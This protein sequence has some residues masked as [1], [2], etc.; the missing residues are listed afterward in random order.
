[1]AADARPP[2]GLLIGNSPN[3]LGSATGPPSTSR[4]LA[5]EPREPRSRRSRCREP[6][7]RRSCRNTAVAPMAVP[8]RRRR[9][10]AHA[11]FGSRF[12][13]RLV[14]G[15]CRHHRLARGP[16]RRRHPFVRE[17]HRRHR[18]LVR[19]RRR[20]RPDRRR[21]GRQSNPSYALPAAAR[22]VPRVAPSLHG[23]SSAER[24]L[25]AGHRK[26]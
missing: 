5:L 25:P 16:C 7:R 11:R 23:G 20:H 6:R 18:R 9:G 19:G 14:H 13:H 10:R 12:Y 15:P 1:M 26:E 22:T 8:R 2:A 3:S 24:R 17:P 4:G 21:H